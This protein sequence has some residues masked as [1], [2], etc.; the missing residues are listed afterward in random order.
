MLAT[1]HKLDVT[2]SRADSAAE[3]AEGAEVRR[4]HTDGGRDDGEKASATRTATAA[5]MMSRGDRKGVGKGK[6]ARGESA[7][8]KALR[9]RMRG[10]VEAEN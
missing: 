3:V 8:P 9:D 6:A 7:V 5:G 2:S 10:L 1:V 4:G